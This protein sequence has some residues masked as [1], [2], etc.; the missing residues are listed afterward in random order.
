MSYPRLN[1]VRLI[2][3]FTQDPPRVSQFQCM[4]GK[5]FAMNFV[6]DFHLHSEASP[7][8]LSQVPVR[9]GR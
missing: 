4:D 7:V 1:M 5:L 2:E 3:C 6:V 9:A 8:C